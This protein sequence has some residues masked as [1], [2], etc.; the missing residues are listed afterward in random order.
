MVNFRFRVSYHNVKKIFLG[1]PGGS[2]VKNLP[3]N[4]EDTG[5]IPH[6][7]RCHRPAERLSLRATTRELVF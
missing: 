5:L 1:F 3:A 2:G 7:G 4:A 6:M